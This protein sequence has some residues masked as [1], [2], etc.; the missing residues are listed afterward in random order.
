[1]NFEM[2]LNPTDLASPRQSLLTQPGSS[3]QI[4]VTRLDEYKTRLLEELKP[5][6]QRFLDLAKLAFMEAEALAWSTLY[7]HL[8]LPALAEEKI[9]C[10]QQ[11]TFH[12]SRIAPA[13]SVRPQPEKI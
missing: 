2:M 9:A 13:S 6:S 11:W 8:F 5:E 7:P 1:M 12:Q 4:I 10:L 3:R